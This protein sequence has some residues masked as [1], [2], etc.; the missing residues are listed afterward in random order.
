MNVRQRLGFGAAV[1]AVCLALGAGTASADPSPRVGGCGTGFVLM[2]VPVWDAAL[3][4]SNGDGWVCVNTSPADNQQGQG[5]ANLWV[6]VD[7]VVP[8]KDA[9]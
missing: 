1:A 2:F 4:H 8:S 9:P 5:N 6:F 3:V 7:N